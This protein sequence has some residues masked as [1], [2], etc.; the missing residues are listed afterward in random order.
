MREVEDHAEPDQPVDELASEP[1]E[2]AA[3][4]L[5]RPVRERVPA[6]PRQAGHPNAQRV[7]D[8]RRPGL[9]AEALDPLEREQQ[10]DPL[11]GLD[12]VEVRAVLTCTTRSA[13]SW[14]ARWNDATSDRASR[15]DPSGC[16]A[17][18]T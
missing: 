17:T 9:D 16:T 1:R 8:L 10:P 2:P 12:G 13:F 18:S 5:R 6:I 7:E 4:V 3:T 11:A 14:S 15:S